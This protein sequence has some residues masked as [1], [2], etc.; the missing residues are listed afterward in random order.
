MH[1]VNLSYVS[2]RSM[3]RLEKCVKTLSPEILPFTPH[4]IHDLAMASTTFKKFFIKYDAELY[5]HE[6]NKENAMMNPVI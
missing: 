3:I 6:H 2:F 4:V 1:F 5:V